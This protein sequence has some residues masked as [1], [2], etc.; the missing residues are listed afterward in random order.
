MICDHIYFGYAASQE[1]Y[2][3][4]YVKKTEATEIERAL[5]NFRNDDDNQINV[6]STTANMIQ[7]TESILKPQERN[8]T[9]NSDS[10]PAP[11]APP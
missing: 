9:S 3:T 7:T 8:C 11:P 6:N 10:P 1:E 5:Q 4:T 2:S